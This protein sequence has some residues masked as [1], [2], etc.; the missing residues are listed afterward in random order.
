MV[1]TIEMT[2][3]EKFKM[4]M[5]CSKKELV[6]MLLENQRLAYEAM[7]RIPISSSGEITFPPIDQT[8]PI[9]QVFPENLPIYTTSS[10][11]VKGGNINS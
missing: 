9:W 10:G 11:Y 1:H 7:N 8:N 6:K 5:K 4:Y 2:D 3:K